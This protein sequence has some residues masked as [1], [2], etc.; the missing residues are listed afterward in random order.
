MIWTIE[1]AHRAYCVMCSA[2]IRFRVVQAITLSARMTYEIQLTVADRVVPSASWTSRRRH[3]GAV[4]DLHLVAGRAQ[5]CLIC[6]C[7]W[8]E[9]RVACVLGPYP[10]G[11]ADGILRA[12][13][14]DRR[15]CLGLRVQ[16]VA[17]HV[18]HLVGRRV[19]LRAG[20]AHRVAR[21][22]A[23]ARVVLAR[24]A[25]LTGLELC[26]ST[27][28]AVDCHELPGGTFGA[29][30]AGRVLRRSARHS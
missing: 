7:G 28:R 2:A 21:G 16:I 17:L 10:A 25:G 15:V 24:E 1:G 19:A 27:R 20:S 23:D 14:C 4:P 29:R 18:V 30:K 13:T 9:E 3:V 8:P 22:V 5:P 11:L 12:S 6:A 26:V